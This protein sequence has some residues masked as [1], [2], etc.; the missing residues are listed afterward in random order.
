MKENINIISEMHYNNGRFEMES[1]V[2]VEGSFADK[3]EFRI[4]NTRG[5]HPCA[6]IRIP[7][8]SCLANICKELYNRADRPFYDAPM[9][10]QVRVHGGFTFGEIF[11][12][13]SK[14]PLWG[15]GVWIGWD[16]GHC[17]DWAGYETEE[18][19]ISSGN[20]KWGIHDIIPEVASAIHLLA[21]EL[22]RPRV[23]R[24]VARDKNG[25]LHLF[26][27]EPTKTEE[28]GTWWDRDY[29]SEGLDQA[30]FPDV[31]WE[32]EAPT[33]VVVTLDTI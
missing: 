20:T 5:M 21:D 19:N 12:K 9:F 23:V 8:D 4:V 11:T 18:E 16:Y 30:A 22:D 1:S 24:Y 33:L 13:R 25:S 7:D 14:E 10:N 17:G 31:K 6:Y 27:V 15:P 28:Y 32:D 3:W 2:I 26:S 29:P